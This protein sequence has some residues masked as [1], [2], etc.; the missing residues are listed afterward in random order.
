MNFREIEL[1]QFLDD[2]IMNNIKTLPSLVDR[3]SFINMS[4]IFCRFTTYLLDNKAR[5][6][7]NV[8]IELKQFS[9]NLSTKGVD[10]AKELFRVLKK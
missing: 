2:W 6:G 8:K 7:S 9:Y 3:S 4:R 5:I 10:E 1:K